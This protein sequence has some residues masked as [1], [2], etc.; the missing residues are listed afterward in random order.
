MTTAERQKK[1]ARV[2]AICAQIEGIPALLDGTLMSKRNRVKRK[3][4]SIHVSPDHC[5]FQYR[6]A[7]GTRRWTRIPKSARAAVER[8]VRAGAR[9]RALEREYRAVLTEMALADDGKKNG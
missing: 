6:S 7:D 4:G 8:L 2:R 1:E 3:D 9:Y 5:T